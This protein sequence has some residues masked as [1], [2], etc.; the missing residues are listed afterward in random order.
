MR[1]SSSVSLTEGKLP[2]QILIFSLPLILSNVLQVLF[3][4]SDIAVV[5]HFAGSGALG[6][7]GSTTII[8]ALFTNIIIGI[9]AG[10]NVVVARY[11][12]SKEDRSVRETVHS[13]AL[14]CLISGLV[15]MTVGLII[16]RPL[17]E[18]LGTKEELI[19]GAELYLR[20]YFC[21]MPALAI[22]NFGNGVLS[23]AGDTGRPLVY[24]LIAGI[25]NVLLNLF[26]VI[27]FALDVAGVAIA[28]ILSQYVSAVLVLITLI[29][30]KE[31]YALHPRELR[32]TKDK[33]KQVALLG[34]ATG[35][36]NAIFQAA[37]LFVQA[38]VNT[39]DATTVEGNSAATNADA[40]V[41]DV[42]SAFY[43]ACSSFMSQNYGAHK[44]KRVRDS[45][46]ISTAYALVI[47]LFMGVGIYFMGERF[48]HIFTKD[49]KVVHAGMWRLS[50]MALSYGFSALMD[51]TIAA[52]RGLG[53]SGVP[54]VIVIMGSCVFRIIWVYTVFAYFHTITSLYLVY[55]SSWTL[56]AIAEILYFRYVYK[57]MVSPLPDEV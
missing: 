47:G 27:G 30:S 55:I 45:F 4:M 20:I 50:V 37:N 6:S 22:Y 11:L 1:L 24:M 25:L 12:G 26:F 41:Y 56:T 38:G 19:E 49:P 31:V 57:K 15:L 42:M 8:V 46:F 9:G 13:S 18:L 54:T 21:G 51:G 10:V 40:L 48:L 35:L 33:T 17:L 14:I 32:F 23:A 2:R 36:Q 29:R 44:K 7:V 34:I 28:S 3:N 43:V 39:F 52:S 16:N 53:K 5:G